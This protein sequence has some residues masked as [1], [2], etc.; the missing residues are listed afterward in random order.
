MASHKTVRFFLALVTGI[1]SLAFLF[2]YQLT[3]GFNDLFGDP[4]DGHIAIAIMEHWKNVLFGKEKWSTPIYFFP[5]KNGLGYND[6]WMILGCIYSLFRRIG[7]DPLLSGEAVN[8]V[9][10][11]IGFASFLFASQRI[12][13]INF[14]WALLGASLFTISNNLFLHA[15]HA[16]L[17]CVS[18]VP[19]LAILVDL[20]IKALMRDDRSRFAI[21]TA[22]FVIGFSGLLMTAFYM[23]W[24][25]AYLATATA[26]IWVFMADPSRRTALFFS[27][28]HN[29]LV[30]GAFVALS[31]VVN[32]PFLHLYLPK[33][34]ET[35]MH[36]LDTAINYS[37]SLFDL[38]N[39]GEGNL[40][41]GRLSAAG[42][43]TFHPEEPAGARFDTGFPFLLLFMSGAGL[44]SAV[45]NRRRG[46]DA[47]D[48][49]IA[50]LAG[51]IGVTWLLVVNFGGISLYAPVYTLFP[52]AKAI[53]IL[54]RYQLFLT[55]PVIAFAMHELETRSR[56]LP[57]PILT[58]IIAC[59]IAEQV[60]IVGPFRLDRT[61]A[62]ARL[63]RVPAP[64]PA[65]QVFFVYGG[66]ETPSW[67]EPPPLL[68][69]RHRA[70]R[71]YEPTLRY[72]YTYNATAMLLAEIWAVPTLN[73]YASF[74][75]KDWRL[76]FPEA[77][78]YLEEI[79]KVAAGIP[80]RRIC[81]L[82]LQEG[83]WFDWAAGKPGTAL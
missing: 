24:F 3:S 27:L 7:F 78:A 14:C 6:G 45:R 59:L 16:Q 18:F 11:A 60:N 28:R 34:K 82:D 41:Y 55:F 22:L 36:S 66:R 23:A 72:I 75:P 29:A 31:V 79:K 21:W 42:Q 74:L 35:G 71:P 5:V 63:S 61:E 33:A 17:F 4:Y 15:D 53:R 44:I 76:F 49:A 43:K 51:G 19:G 73:G 46:G 37:P 65:C 62:M 80:E 8:I 52:G 13:K 26:V 39:V 64:P 83:H 50:A 81:G 70:T 69:T 58:V 47:Q 1:V 32:I 2:R 54:S 57:W 10:R 68:G 30:I 56:R 20:S 77:P 25:F 48:L 12:M 38:V 40:L 67:N 9:V